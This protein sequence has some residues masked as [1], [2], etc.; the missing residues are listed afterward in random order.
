MV[1]VS[2]EVPFI[3][4]PNSLILILFQNDKQEFYSINSFTFFALT[5]STRF[6]KKNIALSSMMKLFTCE[7]F[8]EF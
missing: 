1:N 4:L 5:P 3:L 6:F 7:N 2:I 8:R